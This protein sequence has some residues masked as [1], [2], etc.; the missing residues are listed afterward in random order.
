MNSV[1]ETRKNSLFKLACASLTALTLLLSFNAHAQTRQKVND[2]NCLEAY[3]SYDC[4]VDALWQKTVLWVTAWADHDTE[5]YFSLYAPETSPV[6]NLGYQQWRKQ[7]ELR[8]GKIQTLKLGLNFLDAEA[9]EGRKVRLLFIQH[10][11]SGNYKDIVLKTLV[12]QLIND[13]FFIVEEI[14]HQTLSEQDAQLI[15]DDIK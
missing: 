11:N 15:L 3:K 10:Y 12:Y 6:E 7:R 2:D 5:T 1:T 14:V 8:V 4:T 9:V 13:E